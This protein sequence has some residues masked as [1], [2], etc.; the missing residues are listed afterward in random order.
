MSFLKCLICLVLP[1]FASIHLSFGQNKNPYLVYDGK[2]S[3]YKA[4]S[5]SYF[6][7]EQKVG[8]VLSG[9]GAKGLSHI[10]VIKALEENE[11][12]ID[13]LTGTSMGAIVGGMYA[14]GMTPDEMKKM[15]MSSEFINLAMGEIDEK[16]KF[17]FNQQDPNSSW[18]SLKIAKDSIWE[19][20]LPTGYINPV[21]IDFLMME[22]TAGASAAANYNFD[23][24]LIPFRCVASD[25]QSKSEVV[26]REGHLSEAIRASSTFP[27]YMMPISVGNKLLFDGGLYNNF[28]TNVMYNEFL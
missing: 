22:K 9:G 23:S 26:F 1:G 3:D 21:G 10:G 12:P 5:I 7:D 25:V 20:S 2:W 28:P 6:L 4:T 16:Y 11:I 18:L 8:L 14:I 27:F 15:A 24:L 17:Y 13:Y 19:T